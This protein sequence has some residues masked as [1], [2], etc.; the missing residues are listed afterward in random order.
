MM[1]KAK[2]RP[3]CVEHVISEESD[4]GSAVFELVTGPGIPDTVER[5]DDAE[6][7]PNW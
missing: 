5:V 6:P 3:I 4:F 2:P 7:S 1:M